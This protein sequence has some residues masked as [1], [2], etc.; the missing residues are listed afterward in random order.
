MT[1]KK[2]VKQFLGGLL[3]TLIVVTG[4]LFCGC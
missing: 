3:A 4:L 2:R 1:S